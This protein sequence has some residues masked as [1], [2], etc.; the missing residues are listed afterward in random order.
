MANTLPRNQVDITPVIHRLVQRG[1][2]RRA[3]ARMA[4]VND[5]TVL[6]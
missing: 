6:R 5:K 1:T 2:S 4:G 3:I